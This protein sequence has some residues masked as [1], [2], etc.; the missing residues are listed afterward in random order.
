M[1][2]IPRP[3]SRL[4]LYLYTQ[5]VQE[6]TEIEGLTPGER[7]SLWLEMARAIRQRQLV[8]RRPING[9]PKS[10]KSEG[11][12][13]PYVLPIDINTWLAEQGYSY[14]WDP[15][16]PPQSEATI[17]I[18]GLPR[19]RILAIS[20]PLRSPFN[21]KSLDRALSDTPKWL[22]PARMAKGAPGKSSSLWNPSLIA[23]SLVAKKH[24]NA[25]ALTSTITKYFPEW[26]PEWENACDLNEK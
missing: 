21:Q 3:I 18:Q 6:I 17:S 16:S 22:L 11:D 9:T 5:A 26:L 15:K 24:A 20:W 14:E 2:Q 13:T 19:R 1:N 12:P 23:V 8:T 7:T 25:K 10:K 4:G